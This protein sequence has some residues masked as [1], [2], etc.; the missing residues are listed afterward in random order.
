MVPTMDD[1]SRR[2]G[3]V[4]RINLEVSISVVGPPASVCFAAPGFERVA[5]GATTGPAGPPACPR[6]SA[7]AGP[8]VKWGIRLQVLETDATSAF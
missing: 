2:G 1:G 3:V 5:G 8:Q 4:I 6:G 7:P